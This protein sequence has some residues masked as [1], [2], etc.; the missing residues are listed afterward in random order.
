MRPKEG[1]GNA[2]IRH[3]DAGLYAL[4]KPNTCHRGSPKLGQVSLKLPFSNYVKAHHIS[5]A[6]LS[7]GALVAALV[8]FMVGAF[9]RLLV[10]PVSLGPLQQS[11][12]GAIQ[13]ALPGINLVYDKAALEWDRDED[14]VN[15]VVLG[16][17]ILDQ[18]G[19]VVIAAPK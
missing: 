12:A 19:K 17:R 8:F 3:Q 13:N 2:Q 1:H 5:H 4:F 18:D 15:L 11:L 14:R 10:G 7:M 16:A 6:A 9:V